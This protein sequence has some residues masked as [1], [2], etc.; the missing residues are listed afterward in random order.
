M[1]LMRADDYRANW[2]GY[3]TNQAGHAGIVGLV[4]GALALTALPQLR[5]FLSWRWP[6]D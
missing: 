2:Y 5:S 6:M 1:T 4:L 3:V